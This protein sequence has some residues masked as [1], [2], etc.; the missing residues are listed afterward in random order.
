MKYDISQESILRS[1]NDKKLK[2]VIFEVAS[3]AN[4]HLSKVQNYQFVKNIN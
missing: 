3:R 1:S 4:Q 2:D